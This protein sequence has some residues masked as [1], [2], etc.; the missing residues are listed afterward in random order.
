MGEEANMAADWC[1]SHGFQL[2]LGFHELCN[3]LVEHHVELMLL[4]QRVLG[5]LFQDSL[6]IDQLL[7]P[8][9]KKNSEVFT[10]ML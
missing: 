6:L 10:S 4:L 7:L 1:A 9:I 2:E 8:S 3:S 5:L